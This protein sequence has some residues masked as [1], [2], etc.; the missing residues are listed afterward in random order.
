MNKHIFQIE[1]E[2]SNHAHGN[3]YTP[4]L[5]WCDLD[6]W[7]YYMGICKWKVISVDDKNYHDRD[8]EVRIDKDNNGTEVLII[9]RNFFLN[10]YAKIRKCKVMNKNDIRSTEASKQKTSC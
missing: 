10:D 6:D 2:F 8:R 9:G 5:R 3:I 4:P 1:A 7:V